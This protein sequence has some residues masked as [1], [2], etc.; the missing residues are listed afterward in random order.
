MI[1]MMI[2]ISDIKLMSF[3]FRNH[4]CC[5]SCAGSYSSFKSSSRIQ[6]SMLDLLNYTQGRN[7]KNT[8]KKQRKKSAT[9]KLWHLLLISSSKLL[10]K[11]YII[12]DTGYYPVFPPSYK[13]FLVF[14]NSL[15]VQIL[16]LCG[17]N[18]LLRRNCVRY[19]SWENNSHRHKPS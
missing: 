1:A 2:P 5:S 13:T 7:N 10:T 4:I 9:G 8:I 18:T 14:C 16:F 11:F 12:M 17:Q 6:P 3:L 15:G 19:F